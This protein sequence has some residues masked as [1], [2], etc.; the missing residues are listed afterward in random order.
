MA[1]L[2]KKAMEAKK[3]MSSFQS[4][5]VSGGVG[6]LI[7]GLY[8]LLKVE[9]SKERYI[10]SL[11]FLQNYDSD[12]LNIFLERLQEDFLNSYKKAR[13]ELD[14]MLSSNT[15]IEDLKGFLGD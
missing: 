14:K 15:N 4:A 1:K 7:N 9:I 3:K 10:Q 8:D 13:Q 6:I 12:E 5:G 11:P 2:A